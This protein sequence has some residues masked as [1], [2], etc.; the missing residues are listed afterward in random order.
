M[1]RIFKNLPMYVMMGWKQISMTIP[2][3]LRIRVKMKM[4]LL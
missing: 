4:I 2:V 1:K 3:F